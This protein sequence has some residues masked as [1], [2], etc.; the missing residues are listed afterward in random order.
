MTEISIYI[1]SFNNTLNNSY[2]SY[3]IDKN[4]FNK[5]K[6][7]YKSTN[8]YIKNIYQKRNIF[9]E[10]ID[11]NYT[12]YQKDQYNYIISTSSITLLSNIMKLNMDD[13]PI[14]SNYD[15]HFIINITEYMINGYNVLLEECNNKYYIHIKIINQE[16]DNINQKI[17]QI[18]ELFI[19]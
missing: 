13:I 18:E 5:I 15:N 3:N 16:I 17:K 2:G 11:N 9:I 10:E 1:T 6:N 7:K 12:V 19:E 4:M 8:H 14:L